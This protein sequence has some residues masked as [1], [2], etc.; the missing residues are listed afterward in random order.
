MV[1]TGREAGEFPSELD[2][3][4]DELL[5]SFS[6]LGPLDKDGERGGRSITPNSDVLG[7]FLRDGLAFN[8]REPGVDGTPG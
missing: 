4:I 1:L 5:V 8:V 7:V 6:G 2:L 3:S